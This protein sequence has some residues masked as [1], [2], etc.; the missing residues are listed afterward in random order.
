MIH[1]DYTKRLCKYSISQDFAT[2]DFISTLKSFT[3]SENSSKCRINRV[4]RITVKQCFP[5][6]FIIGETGNIIGIYARL[7]RKK[8]RHC[9]LKYH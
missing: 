8:R 4:F 1:S 5:E 2:L 6:N 7:E 9:F 3:S